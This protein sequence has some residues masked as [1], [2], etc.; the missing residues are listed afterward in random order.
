MRLPL[1]L[2]LCLPCA[3]AV[4]GAPAIG[5]ETEPEVVGGVSETTPPPPPEEDRPGQLPA[6]A[7]DGRVDGAEWSAAPL[8]DAFV[9]NQPTEG[10]PGSE[11][12]ELRVLHD[13]R[14]L[15]V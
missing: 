5:D 15:Y 12:T 2:A 6:P 4:A 7:R 8:F 9:L 11:R 1:S 10:G 13:D 14:H 3:V